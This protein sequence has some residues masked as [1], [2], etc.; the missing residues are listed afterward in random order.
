MEMEK[1]IP[2]IN[3]KQCTPIFFHMCMY[4]IWNRKCMELVVCMLYSCIDMHYEKR[5]KVVE[6]L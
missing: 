1:G 4:M 3:I 2:L 6:T 5:I